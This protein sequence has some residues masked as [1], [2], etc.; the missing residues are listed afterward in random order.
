MESNDMIENVTNIIVSSSEENAYHIAMIKNP[1]IKKLENKPPDKLNDEAY[2]QRNIEGRQTINE[3][4]S[5]LM[6]VIMKNYMRIY[7]VESS[8]TEIAS[9]HY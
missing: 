3:I 8:T 7:E 5:Y 6:K 4:I 1:I 2:V 9:W